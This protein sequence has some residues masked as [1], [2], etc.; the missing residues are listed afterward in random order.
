MTGSTKT[1]GVHYFT[2]RTGPDRAN[3][4]FG[5]GFNL[6]IFLGYS[7][8]FLRI[9]KNSRLLWRLFAARDVRVSSTVLRIKLFSTGAVA[10][11]KVDCFYHLNGAASRVRPS[12]ECQYY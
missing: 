8:Y 6:E 7:L 9:I 3:I 10:M 2:E 1:D 5:R 12:R 11:I 4:F